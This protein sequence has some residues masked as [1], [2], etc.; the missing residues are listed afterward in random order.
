ML[1][2]V[3]IT[4]LMAVRLTVFMMLQLPLTGEIRFLKGVSTLEKSV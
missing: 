4:E 3:Y 1:P 2:M